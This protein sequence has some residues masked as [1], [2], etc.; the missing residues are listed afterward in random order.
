MKIKQNQSLNETNNINQMSTSTPV[1][2]GDT[3]FVDGLKDLDM[4]NSM[5]ETLE[6]KNEKVEVS[7]ATSVENKEESPSKKIDDFCKSNIM[8]VAKNQETKKTE[9][10]KEVLPQTDVA[11]INDAKTQVEDLI[12]SNLKSEN[13]QIEYKKETLVQPKNNN[14]VENKSENSSKN[15]VVENETKK[16]PQMV[17]EEVLPEE[18]I[19]RKEPKATYEEFIPV[20]P[21]VDNKV[22]NTETNKNN[23]FAE[24]EET[25]QTFNELPKI[26][27]KDTSDEILDDKFGVSEKVEDKNKVDDKNA[28]KVEEI[29][30]L[31]DKNIENIQKPVKQ[32]KQDKVNEVEDNIKVIENPVIK[33][34]SEKNTNVGKAEILDN[35]KSHFENNE[36]VKDVLPSKNIDKKSE[37]KND[38]KVINNLSKEELKNIIHSKKNEKIS[39][40]KITNNIN[41]NVKNELSF[42][43]KIKNFNELSFTEKKDFINDSMKANNKDFQPIQDKKVINKIINNIQNAQNKA[44]IKDETL[45]MKDFTNIVNNVIKKDKV[46]VLSKTDDLVSFDTK[47]DKKTDFSD[48]TVE[49]VKLTVD[50]FEP[51]VVKEQLKPQI[52]ILDAIKEQSKFENPVEE[53]EQVK[54]NKINDVK[55]Q[56]L[57]PKNALEMDKTFKPNKNVEN[58]AETLIQPENKKEIK[59]FEQKTLLVEKEPAQVKPLEDKVIQPKQEIGKVKLEEKPLQAN[60]PVEMVKPV[61]NVIVEDFQKTVNK[62][63]EIERPV[64]NKTTPLQQPQIKQEIKSVEVENKKSILQPENNILKVQPKK[65]EEK[66]IENELL[67]QILSEEV[68]LTKKIPAMEE[69]VPEQLRKP[70]QKPEQKEEVV[71]EKPVQLERTAIE[72]Q[73]KQPLEE[74]N[75]FLTEIMAEDTVESLKSKD[76]SM[77]DDNT[78]LTEEIKNYYNL[79]KAQNLAATEDVKNVIN[80]RIAEINDLSAIVETAQE[81]KAIQKDLKSLDVQKVQPKKVETKQLKMTEQDA[82]FFIE[83]VKNNQET[84]QTVA[85]TATQMLQ[86][87]QKLADDAQQ[88]TRV[89]KALA[90]MIGEAAKTNKPFRIDFDKNI[91]VIIKI[92]REGKI[93]AEFLPGDKAVEQFLRTQLPMLRQK[94]NDENIDYKDLNY[95]QSNGGRQNRE[96]RRRG[97]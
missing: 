43:T 6:T 77:I 13:K 46:N 50:D 32:P 63:I 36:L 8:Y 22:K 5:K 79:N 55:P 45:S 1:K 57:Q 92:D 89:S 86:D 70:V 62:P 54:D 82:N 4:V 18:E 59:S 90:D 66:P 61:E 75:K 12:Q 31:L 11:E 87:V 27:K 38:L 44:E 41:N 96:R 17:M 47:N 56:P 15:N 73:K 81:A 34:V 53:I 16:I 84:G 94:F 83:L 14:K 72:P 9:D 67:S 39:D 26:S 29:T 37:T 95:R 19:S 33:N 20:M 85:D 93:S 40:T 52:E 68:D 65:V 35:K 71:I 97:E 51:E 49:D 10:K 76:V 64:E 74:L 24:L 28:S 78:L 25:L 58:K 7:D 69:V 30:D 80:E 23:G 91:S 21:E 48:K 42:D 3:T 2:T 60:K 88:T